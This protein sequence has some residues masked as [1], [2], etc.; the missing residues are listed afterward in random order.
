MSMLDF[1]LKLLVKLEKYMILIMFS[2]CKLYGGIAN[3]DKYK[4]ISY[5]KMC[6]GNSQS[7]I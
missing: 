6:Q 2:C 4:V 3:W 1:K 7:W 5:L